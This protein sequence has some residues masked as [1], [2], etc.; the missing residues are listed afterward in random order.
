MEKQT[1]QKNVF[2]MTVYRYQ[3]RLPGFDFEGPLDLLLQLIERNELPITEIS[4]ANIAEEYTAYIDQL[5]EI[6]P[7]ELSEFLVISAKLLLI[8]SAAL[9]PAPPARPG[10]P[11]ESTTDAKELIAQ[12]REYKRIKEAVRFLQQRH[13]SGYRAYSS[14]R[15][16]PTE[17]HLE[18][19]NS[20]LEKTGR[21][22]SGHS[23]HG[24][25][26]QD[27]LALVKRRL[28]AQQR[29]Q[30]K[31]PLA[32][33][34]QQLGRRVKIE[35]RIELVEVRL[36]AEKQLAFSSLFESRSDE[37]RLELE[38]IVTFMAVLEL[39]RRHAVVAQQDELFGEIY[40]TST[41]DV[42]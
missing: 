23:L 35:E 19:L 21:G 8:K 7:A 25:K 36:K 10:E 6:N 27:L 14:Q 41:K 40:I 26:L 34:Q 3:V 1:R 37:N 24:V 17:L 4:L 12:L 33:N 22:K 5:T 11:E 30:L 38:I 13:E 2:G 18:Q 31:L 15:S 42:E 32:I 16:G 9:L 39:L 28:A 29:E 20:A